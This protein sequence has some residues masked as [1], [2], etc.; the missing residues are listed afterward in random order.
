VLV[1]MGEQQ[2]PGQEGGP[3]AVPVVGDLQDVP[4]LDRREGREGRVVQHQQA[5]PVELADELAIAPIS[6]GE[7]EVL[8]EAGHLEIFIVPKSRRS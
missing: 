3:G 7:A 6:P 5:S 2:L 8:E 4:P 1:P